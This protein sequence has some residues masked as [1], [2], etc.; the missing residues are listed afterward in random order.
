MWRINTPP[1][2][3]GKGPLTSDGPQE[4]QPF[5]DDGDTRSIS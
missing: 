1:V 4:Q 2:A 3:Q 5:A